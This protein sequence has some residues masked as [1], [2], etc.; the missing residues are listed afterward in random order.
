MNKYNK[1][2]VFF[3]RK[4]STALMSSNIWKKHS[5]LKSSKYNIYK[6]LFFN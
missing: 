1:L 6:L 5:K 2:S 3:K 4:N